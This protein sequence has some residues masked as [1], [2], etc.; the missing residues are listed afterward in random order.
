MD[1]KLNRRFENDWT[2]PELEGIY[3][4]LLS[5]VTVPVEVEIHADLRVLHLGAMEKI[6]RNAK[7]IALTECGCRKDRKNCKNTISGCIDLDELA[8]KAL[9]GRNENGATPEEALEAMRKSHKAGLV[10][11]AYTFRKDPEKVTKIC[12]CCSC[13]CQTLSG[14]IRFGLA[15]H[16]IPAGVI[17]VDNNELCTNCGVCVKRCQFEARKMDD[18]KMTYNPELCFGCGLCISTCRPGA[19]RLESRQNHSDK[20][21]IR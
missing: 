21:V 2:E 5:A 14:L 15:K 4:R 16:V 11:M 1:V 19:I 12:S 13:C 17:A 7:K 18:G 6:L 3:E 8:E 10:H 20:A 9:K